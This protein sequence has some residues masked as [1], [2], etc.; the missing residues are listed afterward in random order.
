MRW[1][2]LLRRKGSTVW[3]GADTLYL[4]PGGMGM[5]KYSGGQPG[6]CA[7]KISSTICWPKIERLR[8][9][10]VMSDFELPKKTSKVFLPVFDLVPIGPDRRDWLSSKGFGRVVPAGRYVP[11]S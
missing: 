11:S 4:C 8:L 10:V 2:Y 7:S 9:L 1:S 3:F 5:L 6:L